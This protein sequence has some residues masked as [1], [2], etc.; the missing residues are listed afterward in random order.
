MQTTRIKF[1][2]L[3]PCVF[4]FLIIPQASFSSIRD[5]MLEIHDDIGEKQDEIEELNTK[6]KE[7][8][9]TVRQK[10]RE[11]LSLENQIIIVDNRMKKTELDIESTELQISTTE[12]ELESLN[13][14]IKE[15]QTK[16]ESQKEYLSEF[17]RQ[18]QKEDQ[19]EQLEILLLYDSF[20]D[21]FDH[22]KYLE[23]VNGSLTETL[24]DVRKL[25]D[26]LETQ[27][28]ET[29][30]K[31]QALLKMKERLEDKKFSLE[32]QKISKA[33]LKSRA[34]ASEE[35]FR[36][37]VYELRLEQQKIDDELKNLEANL[38]KKLEEA[39]AGF[40]RDGS[41][42][43]LSW[44]VEPA[45]GISA[46]FHD[47]DYPYRYL[48]EHPAIDI[49]AYQGT[50]VRA[51]APGYVAKINFNGLAYSYLM[52]IHREGISTVYAHLS[53]MSVPVDT[54]V[55]RGQIIGYSGGMPGTPGAGR[56]STGPHLHFEVRLNGIPVD[57]MGY[58][59]NY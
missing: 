18:I 38:R 29:E 2:F 57:P 7:Y 55:E 20:A 23:E 15:K 30:E 1:I 13:L 24:Q 46:T 36:N 21:F 27:K 41:D 51:A 28:N 37:L 5:E 32:E 42:L 31:K 56:L 44:P 26:D 45:R 50:P 39:D 12:L 34:A 22:L 25:K 17:I 10:Q 43:V 48:F 58:L 19:R 6:I 16:I 52:I 8:E 40:L 4:I 9:A 59:I 49:R 53:K 54:Y 33:W 47:P 3:C 11:K 35:K 14:Q